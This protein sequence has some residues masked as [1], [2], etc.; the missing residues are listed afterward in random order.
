[1]QSSQATLLIADDEP[2]IRHSL[3]Q[4]LAEMGYRVRTA[5]DGFSALHEI[6]N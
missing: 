3:S 1:M 5:C 4:S 6:R 2:S